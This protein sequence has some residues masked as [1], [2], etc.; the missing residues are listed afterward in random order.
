LRAYTLETVSTLLAVMHA[1]GTLIPLFYRK[2]MR[3]HG[4]DYARTLATL[5]VGLRLPRT[6]W[7]KVLSHDAG[8]NTGAAP[9]AFVVWRRRW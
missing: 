4:R 1:G 6:R 2:G 3:A 7:L 9:A 8:E 5:R